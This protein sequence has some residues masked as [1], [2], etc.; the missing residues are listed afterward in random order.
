M[1][2]L[3]EYI[4][5]PA[6]APSLSA[7]L[8]HIL[9]TQSP[10]HAWLAHPRLNPQWMPDEGTN[11]TD[12]GTIAHALLLED[13]HSRLSV[14]EAPDWR[15]KDAQEARDDAR[16]RGK[17]PILVHKYQTVLVMVKA[18]KQAIQRAPEI[19][20]AFEQGKPEQT[21]VWQDGDVYCRARPDWLTD[22]R[23]LAIDYKT[24]GGS[25]E[26]ESWSRGQLLS[27]VTLMDLG[28]PFEGGDFGGWSGM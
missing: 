28:Q 11:E 23:R 27:M 18:A 17:V 4:R 6:R 26:P 12:L 19:R 5:D 21:L 15:K 9:L 25:A 8:A 24:V 22:D 10:R 20:K 1:S 14:I 16:S 13:D 3:A 7:S 2:T